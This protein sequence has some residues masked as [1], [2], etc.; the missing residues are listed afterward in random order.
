MVASD[1]VSTIEGLLKERGFTVTIKDVSEVDLVLNKS[2][3][4]RLVRGVSRDMKVIITVRIYG[5]GRSRVRISWLRRVG[6]DDN[7]VDE[8]E[9]MGFNVVV[10]KMGL[11][12]ML[13]E[14][15][16]KVCGLLKKLLDTIT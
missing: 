2:V 11:T 5:G 4:S 10:D 9:S 16:G 1:V 7:I 8:L 14:S 13:I 3:S 12:G 15:T 6:E